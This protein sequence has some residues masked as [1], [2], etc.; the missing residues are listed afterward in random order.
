MIVNPRFFPYFK[1]LALAVALATAA[2]THSAGTAEGDA[3]QNPWAFNLN[4]Y[5]WLPSVDGNFSAGPFNKSADASFIDIAG[6]LRNFPMAFNGHFDAHYERLGFYLDGNYMGMDFRPLLDQGYSKGLSTRMGIMEYGATYRLFGPSASERVAHWEEK[7][8][9]NI[10]DIYAG[11]RTIWLGNE[12]EFTRIGTVS[13]NKSITAPLVG[14]RII[15]EFS[16][17][18]FAMLDGSVG[19]FG[20]DNVSFTGSALGTV[21]YRTSLFGVPASVEAGYKALS[22]KVDKRIL[23]TDVIMHGPFLGLTGYW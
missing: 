13:S 2:S 23:T 6:K 1:P 22:V 11:G 10:L 18:W 19:G 7:S 12:A 14:G 4:A 5:L 21:G 9:S 17:K 16:P 8:R 20:V 3:V 15:V